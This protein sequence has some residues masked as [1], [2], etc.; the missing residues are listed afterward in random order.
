MI[1][2]EPLSAED[3]SAL[4]VSI[5]VLLTYWLSYEY[6]RDPRHA[7]EPD[8]ADAAVRHGTRQVMALLWPYLSAER[9]RQLRPAGGRPSSPA[10]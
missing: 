4:S 3:A 10:A 8:N 6:V 2:G 7:L 9:R 5:V 1:D